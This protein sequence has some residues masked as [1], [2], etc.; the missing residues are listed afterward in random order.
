MVGVTVDTRATGT[1][2]QLFFVTVWLVVTAILVVT[3]QVVSAPQALGDEGAE[4]QV[5]A[6]ADY[7]LT[8]PDPAEEDDPS[9]VYGGM[10]WSVSEARVVEAAEGLFERSR[11]E[12]DV[13]LTNTL[14]ATQLRVPDST[15]A[16]V[17]DDDTDP[18]PG[19]FVDAGARLAVEPGEEIAV[20]LDFEIFD[21]EPELSDFTLQVAE[22]NRVPATIRLGAEP[23]E[24]DYPV[25]AAVDTSPL[26]TT[27][28]SDATRQIVVEPL[29]ASIDVNAGPFRASVDEELAVVKVEVQRT[30]SDDDAGYLQNGYWSLEVDGE[31]VPAILVARSGATAS[32]T[33]EVTLLFAFPAEPDDI[34]VIGAAGTSDEITFSVVLP[35]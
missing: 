7:P 35:G 12:V 25:L 22:P 27:D 16:L 17:T 10:L 26:T 5:D 34:T 20:T 13:T 24:L 8:G 18:V 11:I 29:A 9:V 31:R 4:G 6:A 33:D 14:S 15:V 19:R 1:R 23:D 2:G 3:S 28:P 30:E 32:N 21:P